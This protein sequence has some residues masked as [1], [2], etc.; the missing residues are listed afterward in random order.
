MRDT[1]IVVVMAGSV[2]FQCAAVGLC[3]YL[4][5]V[6]GR[7]LAWGLIMSAFAL[8]IVRRFVAFHWFLA[9]DPAH[10]FDLTTELMVFPISLLAALGFA[11]VAPAFRAL[12]N[13]ETEHRD[14]QQLF[15]ST[16]D[17]LTAHIAILD[18]TGTIVAVNPA[19]RRFAE[20]NSLM[21]PRH[22]VGANYLALCDAA[23]R[24]GSTDAAAMAA[25]MREVLAGRCEEFTLEYPCHGVGGAVLV[26]GAGYAHQWERSHSSG[27]GPRKRDPIEASLTGFA[28][29]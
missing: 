2:L 23:E 3:L 4:G 9:A 17:A 27:C 25:G 10:P 11:R 24:N 12:R 15:H 18:D 14:A 13:S 16:L 19:W 28:A 1:L 26:C 22:A 29:E 8:L 21:M 5:K 7:R 6:T 20:N